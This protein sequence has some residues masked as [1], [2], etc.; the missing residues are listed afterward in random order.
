MS[1]RRRPKDDIKRMHIV[2]LVMIGAIS[3]TSLAMAASSLKGLKPNIVHIL[4]DDLGWQDV[5]CYYRDYH[6]DEPFYETSHMDRLAKRGIRFMQAYSPA[7]TCAP[8]R[9]A[10]MTGQYTSHNGIYH[11]NMGCRIPRARRDTA[12]MLDPYY[13]GRIMP[14]KP[15]IPKALK[16]VGYTTAHVGKWHISA[17]SGFPA[18]I[19]QGFDFSFDE[20]HQY[21]DPEIYNPQ[22]PKMA[23]FSG[24]FAQPKNRLKD[25]FTDPRFP[26]L[27]DDRPYDSMVDLSSRW[28]RK[29]GRGD[30]PFFLN[31]C[32]SLV[33]GPTMTRDRKRLAHYCKKLGIPFPTDPGSISDPEKPGHHNAYYAGMVDSV[34]WIVGQIV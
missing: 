16:K 15:V 19:Q 28:L 7:V 25:A 30:K 21:N 24:L 18:P 11:V 10:Y 34:D 29:V 33:H 14:G 8:S 6:K 12:P 26:L 13:V 17:S 9:A 27:K 2:L 5:A 3:V 23:N 1:C 4:V 31:L 22:D 32:P 20:H